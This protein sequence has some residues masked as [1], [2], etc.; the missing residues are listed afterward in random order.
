MRKAFATDRATLWHG[1][2]A[3]IASVIA[4]ESI[5]AIVTDPPA[6]ISFMGKAWDG[7]RGG[8][9]QWIAWLRGIMRTAMGLLKPGGHALVWALP[10]TSHWT[11]TAIEDAGF[12]IRD[13]VVHL[14]GTGFPKSLDVSKA[15]DAAAGGN[16]PVIG[17]YTM[18]I[19]S[20]APG[21][22]PSQG[23][24]YASTSTVGVG[25]PIT[26]PA[27]PDAAR[28]AGYGTSLKPGYEGWVLAR[29]PIAILDA[30]R[31]VDACLCNLS[32]SI[33]V[34]DSASSRAERPEDRTCASAAKPAGKRRATSVGSF[35]AMDTSP[36]ASATASSLSIVSSWRRTLAECS[37]LAS[38]FTTAMASSLTT[39]LQTLNSSASRITPASIIRAASNHDGSTSL[40]LDVARRFAALQ[41]KCDAIRIL[42]AT[43]SVGP[44][45]DDSGNSGSP[46]RPDGSVTLEGTGSDNWI[47]A[48]KPLAGT[49]A[50]NAIAYGTGGLRI[51][52]CR[53]GTTD[54]IASFGSPRQSSGG[55][56][57]GTTEAREQF[58]Q[59]SLGRFPA[60]VTLDEEAAA[61]LDRQSG[62]STDGVAV[63]RNV[64]VSPGAGPV[65][66]GVSN[67][68]P[69]DD[70][71]YGGSGGASRFFYVAKA[72]RAEKDAG[73]DHLPLRTGG[74]ATDGNGGVR[75][76]HPTVK[77]IALMR[78]LCRL[79][80][81]PGG[82]VL[83]MF[84]GSG[85]T[86]LA[87][88]AE[89]LRFVGVER[90][91]EFVDVA[92]GRL[93]HVECVAVPDLAHGDAPKVAPVQPSLFSAI[94]G[95]A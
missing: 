74:D 68:G 52:D 21:R 70:V 18:P 49:V 3:D 73:L 58:V 1:D 47:L 36:S 65:T 45:E 42:T 26:A 79:I 92:A 29:K 4:P 59:N 7:D 64:G 32:A 91:A 33:A 78:W 77:S 38:T 87:A 93:A 94:G 2:C 17:E 53:I 62:T 9:D 5:D 22:S 71:G 31:M 83:D 23:L 28:F 95:A 25:R 63:R 66:F 90:E 14:F 8:R 60:N 11:A 24:G 46:S 30:V 34:E 76:H 54:Q 40:V 13:V 6:G 51:D 44:S 61:E 41:A 19:D 56:L 20:T 16:R 15:I 35:A 72:P 55:I 27:T 84:A 10:R 39:D 81:P 12:E 82:V 37:D 75:N 67:R 80:T 43:A 48:R 88:L 86:G 57:N 85:T 89:G 69:E 50:S